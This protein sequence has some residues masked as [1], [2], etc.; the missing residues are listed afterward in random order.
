MRCD[1]IELD[2]GFVPVLNAGL[3]A[4]ASGAECDWAGRPVEKRARRLLDEKEPWGMLVEDMSCGNYL[5]RD[6]HEDGEGMREGD[7]GEEWRDMATV[8]F[9]PKWLSQ[10]PNAP[11][12]WTLCRTCA[13]RMMNGKQQ[14]QHRA[15]GG[16]ERIPEYCPL[17]LS[18]GD[19]ER[20]EQAVYA[21]VNLQNAV[22]IADPTP[23]SDD[24]GEDVEM[25]DAPSTATGDKSPAEQI[26]HE[27]AKTLETSLV[28]LLT[29]FFRK[30]TIIPL[31]AD[32]QHRFGTRG[33]FTTAT[34]A[35]M[36]ESD[37]LPSE[38]EMANAAM[39][40]GHKDP[41]ENDIWTAMTLRDCSLFLKVWVRK[42]HERGMEARI[43]CKVGDLDL[44]TGDG[45]RAVYWRDVER[46][47]RMGGWYVKRDVGRNCRTGQGMA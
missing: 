42:Q 6:E 18:S 19:Q 43:E 2:P 41:G 34:L 23:G 25:T 39:K 10:S 4:E 26:S 15:V 32:L 45:G 3:R 13:V 30:S 5:Y 9:K 16:E 11:A 12:N 7:P 47:L 14:Q 29:H 36:S 44:K 28:T 37:Q 46:R 1:L 24:E 22:M 31:L 20:I 35:L 33:V 27:L 17:D 21:I 40:I 8:E 38:E